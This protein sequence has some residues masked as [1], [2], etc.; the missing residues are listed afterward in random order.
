E[1]P[2]NYNVGIG[3][4]PGVMPA[5][6]SISYDAATKIATISGLTINPGNSVVVSIT[7]VK[8][9]KGAVMT[10]PGLVQCA[11]P[12]AAPSTTPTTTTTT[13]TATTTFGCAFLLVLPIILL[14]LGSV[15]LVLRICIAVSWF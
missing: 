7:G 14:A 9:T 4:A 13:G 1:D 10:A 12:P 2:T 5:A 8:S 6:N 3:G 11:A 15:L